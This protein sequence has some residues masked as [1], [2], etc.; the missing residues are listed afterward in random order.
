MNEKI[1]QWAENQ[2]EQLRN[3]ALSDRAYE[4]DRT[5]ISGT[6]QDIEEDLRCVKV[7]M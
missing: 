4:E 3:P 2:L 7:Y 5:G 1:L 6:I